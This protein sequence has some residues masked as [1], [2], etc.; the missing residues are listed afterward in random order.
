[1]VEN[2]RGVIK[3]IYK[4][5]EKTGIRIIGIDTKEIDVIR[6]HDGLVES[7]GNIPKYEC[8][9]GIILTGEWDN[10]DKFHIIL[11]KPYTET[12]EMS[13]KLIKNVINKIKKLEPD[14]RISASG[15]KSIL[16][17]MGPDVLTYTIIHGENGSEEVS[18]KLPKIKKETIDK[19]Y[20]GLYDMNSSVE[21]YNFLAMFGIP[22]EK[23][24]VIKQSYGKKA[25][26]AIKENPYRVGISAKIDF[27]TC[28]QIG[29]SLNINPYNKSRIKAI[30][31]EAIYS[32]CRNSGSTYITKEQF[33]RQIS[34]IKSRSSYPNEEIPWQMAAIMI[35]KMK[36]I[37][38]DIEKLRFYIK[39][40]YEVEEAT[41]KN[42]KRIEN[43]K[44][45]YD[46]CCKNI[47]NAEAHLGIKYAKEQRESFNL[48]SSSGIKIITGGPGTGKT[49]V[50]NGILHLYKEMHPS[51]EII[52]CAPTG[53]AAQRMSDVTEMKAETIHR[54]IRCL[55]FESEINIQKNEKN[56][57]DAELIVVDE[58]SMVGIELFSDLLAAIKS[59]TTLILVG[60]ENQL[61]SVDEGN[62]LH[63]LISSKK[64]EMY[65][66]KTVYR[67][68][69]DNT[70]IDNANTILNGNR[71]LI[72]NETFTVKEFY[73]NKNAVQY[74]TELYKNELDKHTEKSLQILSP[75][76]FKDGGTREIN[77]AISK[78]KNNEE[79]ES[80]KELKHGNTV[81]HINDRAIFLSN[82]YQKDYYNGDIGYIT[83]I[84]PDQLVVDVRGN[85]ITVTKNGLSDL[86]LAYAISIHKS[87]GSEADNVV[88]LLPDCC[89][90]MMNR[91]LLFTAVTRAK[92]TVTIVCVNS[93]LSD[94][95]HTTK[96][97]SRRTSLTE[98]LKTA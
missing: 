75:V 5:N 94:A 95:I 87:Q 83:E 51:H 65:R 10:E 16:K 44:I 93:A 48:L 43:K 12:E 42:L 15:I 88:I 52:L 72:K 78:L 11:A 71:R 84:L 97:N 53:R 57:L 61:Q 67:Q 22:A 58:M 96:T 2:F 50:I 41:A 80:A 36:G 68:K 1:M 25:L 37:Y 17:I 91:N 82:N 3:K 81:Y 4:E 54:T 35:M 13:K 85:S 21:L 27:F 45:T 60:D 23:G 56:P 89:G 92:K 6:N 8:E 79:I 14:F 29:K 47:E 69:G 55:P 90:N 98:K 62:V 34:R 32:E 59:G 74:V 40:L 38:I 77:Q 9:I 20:S 73:D 39:K 28:D 63:D 49:T 70:I 26:E 46:F 18:K 33:I 86:T 30:I 64:F 66:L 24:E 76:K 31:Y 7:Y 19:I